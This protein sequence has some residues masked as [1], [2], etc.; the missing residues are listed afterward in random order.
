MNKKV[1][2]II[3]NWNG[4]EYLQLCLASLKRCTYK[5][6]EVI[7]VDNASSDGSLGLLSKDFPWVKVI[8][9]KTN[10]GFSKANNRGVKVCSGEYVLF[11]NNDVEV[12]QD[13]LEPLVELIESDNKIACVQPKI[14]YAEKK[15][16]IN[17]VGSFFT[18][19]GFLYHYG[20]RKD[21]NDPKY[22]KRL[23]IYSAK[24][25][26]MLVC[27]EIFEEVGLFDEDFYLYF[28]E[29]DLC[30]RIWLHG[31]TIYYEPAS[32]VYHCEA[33]SS[34]KW[35]DSTIIY[36]LLR[37]RIYSYLKN[38]EITTII[39]VFTV[40]IPIYGMLGIGYALQLKFSVFLAVIRSVL[41]N[42]RNIPLIRKK[43]RVIQK[44]IRTMSDEKLFSFIKKD[45]PAVYYYY[46]FSNRLD[47]YTYEKAL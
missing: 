47:N 3:A 17:A 32:V 1:S 25:A 4:K 6:L 40:M 7:V 11:L 18:S 21:G 27:K 24:G 38:L 20:Y 33:V 46:S 12:T 5:S 39:K 34:K 35:N 19:S 31:Y 43:R 16:L 23:P 15:H 42:L 44:T 37:N 13:F 30:H 36:L 2:V 28:E 41:W 14:L 9:N 29:T 22:N 45:P 26:A 10:E 8:K